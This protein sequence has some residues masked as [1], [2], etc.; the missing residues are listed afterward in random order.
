MVASAPCP[1]RSV[2]PTANPFM[3]H[4]CSGVRPV[5]SGMLGSSPRSLSRSSSSWSS[6]CCMAENSVWRL[7]SDWRE[8][9]GVDTG[10]EQWRASIAATMA[11]LHSFASASDPHSNQSAFSGFSMMKMCSFLPA[12]SSATSRDT[13]CFM[14]NSLLAAARLEAAGAAPAFDSRGSVTMNTGNSNNKQTSETSSTLC[15]LVL[16]LLALAVAVWRSEQC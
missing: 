11:W 7:R 15:S 10:D 12:I 8:T 13:I 9:F 16:L 4:L 14:H 1:N 3:M 5:P 6:C 2:T